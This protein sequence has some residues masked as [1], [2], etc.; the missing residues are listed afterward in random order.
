LPL[1]KRQNAQRLDQIQRELAAIESAMHD[2]VQAND[3]LAARFAI[4]TSIPGVSAITAF[5]L[6]VE[7]PELGTLQ[8]DEAARLAGFAPIVRQP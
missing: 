4:L 6:L 3:E 7:M 1:L 5:A 2:F 8:A